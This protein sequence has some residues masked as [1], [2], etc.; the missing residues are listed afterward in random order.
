MLLLELEYRASAGKGLKLAWNSREPP[1]MM[2]AG[3]FSKA[4]E[5][6]GR[7]QGCETS[8]SEGDSRLCQGGLGIQQPGIQ[9]SSDLAGV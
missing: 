3:T 4:R 9:E 8:A 6:Q 2:T 7:F 5:S 1:A